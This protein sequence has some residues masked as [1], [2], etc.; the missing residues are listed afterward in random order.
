[1]M[2]TATMIN[3]A[4]DLRRFLK[5]P[6]D[7][8][9]LEQIDRIVKHPVDFFSGRMDLA[10]EFLTRFNSD[11]GKMIWQSLLPGDMEIWK[12]ACRLGK[13]ELFTQ[14]LQ[15]W[16]SPCDPDDEDHFSLMCSDFTFSK[17]NGECIIPDRL[18]PTSDKFDDTIADEDGL[19]WFY[20]HIC[21]AYD[22]RRR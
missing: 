21:L 7:R 12:V 9:T 11:N 14:H 10:E 4:K 8:F 5:E 2:L 16:V 17:S 22:G 1:M 19:L 20:E 6:H 15:L 18:N 3:S 13:F